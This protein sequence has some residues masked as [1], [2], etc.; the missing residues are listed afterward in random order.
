MAIVYS[1]TFIVVI[2]ILL[3]SVYTYYQ[4]HLFNKNFS[5]KLQQMTTSDSLSETKMQAQ[6]NLDYLAEENYNHGSHPIPY[7]DNDDENWDWWFSVE[8]LIKNDLNYTDDDTKKAFR[9]IQKMFSHSF[10][11]TLNTPTA[12]TEAILKIK[13]EFNAVELNKNNVLRG[14]TIRR[15]MQNI[16]DNQPSYTQLV[17]R[18]LT[19][20]ILIMTTL[21]V[22]PFTLLLVVLFFG[23]E[24]HEEIK[25]SNTISK[26]KT[27]LSF[28]SFD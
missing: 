19:T 24:I 11:S 5:A 15:D 22:I 4:E 10:Q 27:I 28:R 21:F 9:L 14:L 18:A 13:D 2:G 20:N 7:K 16:A 26:L 8:D 23:F 12:G 25:L 6:S 3:G 17:P 1:L